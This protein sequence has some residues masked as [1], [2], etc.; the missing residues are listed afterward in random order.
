MALLSIILWDLVIDG[1]GHYQL[2]LVKFFLLFEL[3]SSSKFVNLSG[4][5]FCHKIVI[6]KICINCSI[7]HVK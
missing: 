4:K 2:F 3:I 1:H 5:Q 6:V 7:Y